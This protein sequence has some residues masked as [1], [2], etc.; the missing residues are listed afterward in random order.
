MQAQKNFR[1]G[2]TLIE[3]LI[4]IAVLLILATV[5][6]GAFSGFRAQKTL[7]ATT[8]TV[9][10]GFS[11]ARLNTMSSKNDGRYGIHI[12]PTR[13]TYFLAPT[14]ATGTATNSILPLPNADK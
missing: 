12:E 2:I 1:R 6:L 10:A 11:R 3:I 9:I 5:I 4:V 7:D 14:F 13:L 8:E